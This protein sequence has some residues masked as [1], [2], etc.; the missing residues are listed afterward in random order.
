MMMSVMMMVRDDIA[1]L[2]PCW[3][4][5]MLRHTTVSAFDDRLAASHCRRGGQ[6]REGWSRQGRQL[7][8]ETVRCERL[9]CRGKVGTTGGAAVNVNGGNAVIRCHVTTG[10][11]IS[12]VSTERTDTITGGGGIR[13][14]VLGGFGCSRVPVMVQMV[15]D[16]VRHTVADG[17]RPDYASTDVRWWWWWWATGLRCLL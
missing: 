11:S 6:R 17:D 1:H 14:G 5:S 13:N 10:T 7:R 16:R 4:A 12:S 15:F 3:L 8:V 2:R 9:G